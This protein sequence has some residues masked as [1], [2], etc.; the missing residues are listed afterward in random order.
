M[1]T[2]LVEMMTS[3]LVADTSVQVVLPEE[4][5]ASVDATE[6]TMSEVFSP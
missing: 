5:M 1:E 6:E 4:E 3:V 2:Y